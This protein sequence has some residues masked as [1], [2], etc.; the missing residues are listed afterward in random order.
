MKWNSEDDSMRTSLKR[1]SIISI[2]LSIFVFFTGCWDRQELN[3]LAIVSGIGVDPGPTE[4]EITVVYQVVNPSASS[5]TL[6]VS[7]T[8]TPFMTLQTSA[9]TIYAAI[10]KSSRE[11]SR[12]L[13]FGHLQVIVIHSELAEKSGIKDLLDMMYRDPEIRE[14]IPV[15]IAKGQKTDDVLSNQSIL[16]SN[17][18]LSILK[19][20]ENTY[21]NESKEF[22]YNKPSIR[23]E[24]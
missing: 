12:K 7:S 3:Q 24:L 15:V 21:E 14:D 2:I 22:I 11:I 19:H 20:L 13:Y 1:M 17:N 4:G 8:M 9:K 23:K 6:G 5:G 16:E 18:S 10:R